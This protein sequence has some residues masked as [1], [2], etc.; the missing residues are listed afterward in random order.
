MYFVTSKYT[1]IILLQKRI[2]DNDDS[3]LLKEINLFWTYSMLCLTNSPPVWA[4]LLQQM[5]LHSPG[6]L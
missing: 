6:Q 3:F 4:L 2:P 5:Q 1:D